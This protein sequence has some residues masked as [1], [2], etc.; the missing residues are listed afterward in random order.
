M[1]L[2][3]RLLAAAVAAA[4]FFAQAAPL[5]LRQSDDK[6]PGKYIIRLKPDTDVSTI[7][8]HHNK[9]RNI[10]KRNLAR[11]NDGE[12]SRGKEREYSFGSFKGYAGSFDATTVEELKALP[13]VLTVEED[14]MM[15]TL[16]VN[17]TKPDNSTTSSQLITRK[18]AN[19][20]TYAQY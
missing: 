5:S 18:P 7:A 13:E 19:F 2:F 15:H 12:E 8:A 14:F 3:T 17:A 20:S 6:I 9:V 16:Q 10:H 1:Q 4:P 11:R